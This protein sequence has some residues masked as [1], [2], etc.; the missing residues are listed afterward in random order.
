MRNSA[1]GLLT[2]PSIVVVVGDEEVIEEEEFVLASGGEKGWGITA[3]C[4]ASLTTGL[5]P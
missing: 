2:L 5:G 1:R 3:T 4:G